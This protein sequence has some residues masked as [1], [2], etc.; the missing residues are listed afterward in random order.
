MNVTWLITFSWLGYVMIPGDFILGEK[1]KM[2]ISDK[3]TKVGIY[4]YV[5]QPNA[6][7]QNNVVTENEKTML[8]KYSIHIFNLCF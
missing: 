4:N 3:G 7:V 1:K 5:F 6:T 2:L 8:L